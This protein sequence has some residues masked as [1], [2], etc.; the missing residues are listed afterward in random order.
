MMRRGIMI[1]YGK[2][3]VISIAMAAILL[4]SAV[5]GNTA[6]A[7]TSGDAGASWN[8]SELFV[9]DAAFQA[10]VRDCTDKALP[11]FNS[12]KDTV[13]DAA[14]LKMVL[15]AFDDLSNR[16]NNLYWYACQKADL[17][18]A[19]S[20]AASEKKA[21]SDLNDSLNLA[22][23]ALRNMLLSKDEAFWNIA[24]SDASLAPWK[25]ML[26]KIKDE[27]KYTLP[28]NE[29][30]LLIP[31]SQA[32]DNIANTAAVLR[33]GDMEWQ[34]I[35][36]AAGNDITA[37]YINY[38][39][40][41]SDPDRDYR[42]RYYE[43]YI[44]AIAKY[45]DTFAQALNGYTVAEEKL[46]VLHHYDSRLDETTHDD[47]TSVEIYNALISGARSGTGILKR[48]IGIREKALNIGKLY[49][50]DH[51]VP[52]GNAVAPVI[53]YT[54]A[55]GLIKNALSTLGEDYVTTLDTAFQNGWIDAYPAEKKDSGAYSSGTVYP[56]PWILMNYT[57]DYYSMSTLAHELGHAVHGFRSDA[58]GGSLYNRGTSAFNSEVASTTNQLLLSRYMI[59][60]AANNSEKLYYVQQEL[61][62]LNNTFYGQIE[63]ADFEKQFHDLSMSGGALTADALDKMF[64]DISKI[65]SPYKKTDAADSYWGMVPHFYYN[66]YVYSYAMDICIACRVADRIYAG[67]QEELQNYRNFL[68]A[69]KSIPT[70]ELYKMLGV[71][72]SR[73][74]YITAL[75]DR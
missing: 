40:A 61:D 50:Y 63:F 12:L 5:Q 21:A 14:S 27:A 43:A 52:I 19:D 57:D 70:T 58:A 64:M 3:K 65:Y 6:Y 69:G 11:A 9:N 8:L 18:T 62:T 17:N 7:G 59:D 73:P 42:K 37:N 26:Q 44:G 4:F 38:S 28:A 45:R 36:D 16:V 30:A 47:E 46:S 13:N 32:A 71:D 60:H 1:K 51:E 68:S 35:K 74:D 10:E 23:K 33:N 72:I 41:M 48:E 15:E 56:H 49:S 20:E 67:D 31:T 53:S 39:V 54:D 55:Q 29:E 24:L 2:V 75:T 25:R 34:I 66:Y 22:D